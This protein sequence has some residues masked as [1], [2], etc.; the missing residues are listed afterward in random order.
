MANHL[1]T[2]L[3]IIVFAVFVTYSIT[4]WAY[5]KRAFETFTPDDQG[6]EQSIHGYAYQF[7]DKASD[8]SVFFGFPDDLSAEF[9]KRLLPDVIPQETSKNACNC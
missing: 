2:I 3:L 6:M 7:G 9:S 5:I 8:S 1:L 4:K